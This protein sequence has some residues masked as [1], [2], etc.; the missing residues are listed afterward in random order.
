MRYSVAILIFLAA[1]AAAAI[2]LSEPRECLTDTECM[3]MHGGNGDP[4]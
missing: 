3:Q 1:L 2:T 4:D